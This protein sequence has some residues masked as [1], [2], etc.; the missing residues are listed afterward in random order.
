[1]KILSVPDDTNIFLLRDING[2]TRIQPN[3]KPDEKTS[4]SKANFSRIQALWTVARKN[5]IVEPGQM[6]WLQLYIKLFRVH[7]VNSIFDNSN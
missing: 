6:V 3:L 5:R 2:H 7:F 4:S 1:M